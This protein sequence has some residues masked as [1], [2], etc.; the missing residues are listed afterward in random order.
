METPE[1]FGKHAYDKKGAITASNRRYAED[2]QRLR[3]YPC[4]DHWHLT[5]QLRGT[6]LKHGKKIRR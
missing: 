1:C 5:K 3:I 2:H 6:Y 4:G